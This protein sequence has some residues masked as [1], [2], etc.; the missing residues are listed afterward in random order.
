MT[1]AVTY[2]EYHAAPVQSDLFEELVSDQFERVF[3][4][5][6]AFIGD[7]HKAMRHTESVFRVM[8]EEHR[9]SGRQLYQLVGKVV[10]MLP[11]S[12]I[13]PAGMITDDALCLL[14]KELCGYG[15]AEI[16]ELLSLELP[17]VKIG[18]S[19]ARQALLAA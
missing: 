17:D 16:A 1:T 15:Y 18:I 7:H 4:I 3:A 11:R 19:R 12:Q 8:D 9:V 2:A 10:R 13:L 14:F 6:D 5:I